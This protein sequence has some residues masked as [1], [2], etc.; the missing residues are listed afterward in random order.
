MKRN[1]LLFLFILAALFALAEGTQTWTQSSYDELEKGS[2]KGVAIR[3]DGVLELA[4]AFRAVYTSPSTYIW[5][6]AS[7]GKGD[8]YAAAGAPARVYRI[9][10]DGRATVIFAPKELQ[11]QAIAIGR[12]GAIYAATSPDG[13][14]YK[15][16][17][18]PTPPKAKGATND[19]PEMAVDPG[20]NASVF[21]DPKT[22][23]IWDIALDASGRLYVAT[24]D[25]GEIFRVEKDGTGAVFFKSDEAHIRVLAFDKKGD[26]IAGSDGSGLIYRIAPTGEAFVLYSAPKKEI[27]ALAVN[28]A[29]AI[30]AAGVGDK[31]PAVTVPIPGAPANPP[32]PGPGGAPGGAPGAAF[33]FFAGPTGGSEIYKIEPD[34][35]PLRVWSSRDDIIYAL[36]FDNRGHLLAGTGNKG[37]VY[38]IQDNGDFTDLLKA[39]ATQVTAF[40]PDAKGGL[41]AATSNLGKVFAI[42][43]APE[44]DGTY[45][46]DV[47]DAKNFSRWGRAEVR[48][49]G[50][51]DLFARSGNVDNPDRNWSPWTRVE[52]TDPVLKVPAARFVQWRAVLHPG[53]DPGTIDSVA[54]NYLSRNIAPE[55]DDVEVDVGVRFQQIPRMTGEQPVVLGNAPAQPRI[56]I[57]PPA[58]RDPHS[59]ALRWTTHDDNDDTLVYSIYYRGDNESRWK[60]LK[61]KLT[62]KYY[63]FDTAL[64]P[65]G[66]YQVRVVASDAPSHSSDEAL[67]GEAV[68]EHFDVDTTP[69]QIADLAGTIE[70]HAVH[71]T[72]R[73][74]DAYSPIKRAEY[75]LDAGDWQYVEPIGHISDNKTE[76]YDLTIPLGTDTGEHVVTVRVYDRFDNLATAKTVVRAK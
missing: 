41:F 10:A 62:D 36:G 17:G 53:K 56:E 3:S 67:T 70:V 44:A 6:L 49:R 4:P 75:S 69:P 51:F 33:P 39:S 65:D 13:K 74:S 29:G 26:L 35:T 54:L 2:A 31:R 20:Y 1:L 15:I 24:G 19:T 66:G 12:D 23:Y 9:G 64:L 7:D 60:L 61:D 47:F 73:A 16:T 57:A 38:S 30:Y 43:S 40:A 68:S 27:T 46:S 14:I 76:N 11:V 21:F 25:R 22:K 71:V 34:G 52:L 42:G 5:A 55:V 48:G 45:E 37:R 58:V 32:V 28:D 72:F 50:A 59:I 63:S 8:V 18:T